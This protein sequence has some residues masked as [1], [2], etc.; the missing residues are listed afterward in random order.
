[1]PEKCQV[2]DIL[3]E[4]IDLYVF[5]TMEC[6]NEKYDLYIDIMI[7]YFVIKISVRY[8]WFLL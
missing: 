1:M 5:V 3:K 4:Q 8:M 2:G 6:Y 7:S